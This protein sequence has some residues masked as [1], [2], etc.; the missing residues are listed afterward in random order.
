MMP[1]PK[2]RRLHRTGGNPLSR[3]PVRAKRASSDPVPVPLVRLIC[4]EGNRIPPPIMSWNSKP[5][6]VKTSMAS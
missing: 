6:L 5:P 3:P 1:N 4:Y 2:V